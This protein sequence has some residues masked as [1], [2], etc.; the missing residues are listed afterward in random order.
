MT[1][2]V[3]VAMGFRAEIVKIFKKW[4]RKETKNIETNFSS[5][6]SN[7]IIWFCDPAHMQIANA[8]EIEEKYYITNK[9]ANW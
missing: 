7:Q 1:S 5:V 9:L 6:H 2:V 8:H 4:K 3:Y